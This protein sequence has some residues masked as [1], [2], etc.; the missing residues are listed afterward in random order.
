MSQE[1]R[2]AFERLTYALNRWLNWIGAAALLLMVFLVCSNI[3]GRLFIQPIKGVY[4]IVGFLGGIAIGFAMG[5]TQIKKGHI[6]V[7]IL[8]LRLRPRARAIVNSIGYLICFFLFA[9]MA[10]QHANFATSTWKVGEVSETLKIP[11]FPLIY[12]VAFGCIALCLVLLVDFLKSL[13]KAVK[14]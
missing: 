1:K 7:E 3:L 8:V 6:S 4:E 9:L 10:W 13:S 2:G 14:K 5:Y 12:G 11:F